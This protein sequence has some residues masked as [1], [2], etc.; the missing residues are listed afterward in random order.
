MTYR[1]EDRSRLGRISLAVSAVIV[2]SLSVQSPAAGTDETVSLNEWS[3]LLW[4]AGIEGDEA[5]MRQL[6][7]LP[8]GSIASP[9]AAAA[10]KN[11]VKHWHQTREASATELAEAQAEAKVLML[12]TNNVL[13]PA[14]G[15]PIV[16]PSQDMVIGLYYITE[17][18]EDL[19]NASNTYVDINEA[20]LAYES[21]YIKL[22]TPIKVRLGELSG[23]PAIHKNLKSRFSELISEKPFG[24]NE[25]VNT[26]LGRMY[27]N[28]ILKINFS[29]N[30][31]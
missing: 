10:Y 2:L 6:I 4:N 9:E 11:C 17:C 1:L 29:S 19:D 12:S 27:F 28:T 3:D 15:N 7:E 18:H 20:Q 24:G 30:S 26:T 23:D 13:S 22:Q 5:L 31:V 8:P 14:S 25:L 16:S 21:G